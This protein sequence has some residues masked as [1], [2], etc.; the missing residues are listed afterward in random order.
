MLR[1]QAG[2]YQ[3]TYVS[4]TRLELHQTPPLDVE[5]SFTQETTG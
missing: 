4:R 3:P 2:R 5:A 1:G